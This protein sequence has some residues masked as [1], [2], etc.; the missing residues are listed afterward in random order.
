VLLGN[1]ATFMGEAIEF[2]PLDMKV[3]NNPKATI[4]LER[5]YRQGWSL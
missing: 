2:D 1:V 5:E 3:L 4:A